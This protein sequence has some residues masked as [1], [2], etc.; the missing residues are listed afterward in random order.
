MGGD[1]STVVASER[2]DEMQDPE[3]TIVRAMTEF[4]AI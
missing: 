2:L 3:L 4:E 1:I